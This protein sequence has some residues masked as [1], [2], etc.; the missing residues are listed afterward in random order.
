MRHFLLFSVLIASSVNAVEPQAFFKEHCVK[1]HGED[2]QKGD[3]RLD[4]VSR[5]D[6]GLWQTIYEQVASE[7]MPPD[8]EPQPTDAERVELKNHVLALATEGS[9]P[10][11]TGFRRLNK[12]EYSNTV[13]DL[14]GLQNGIYDPGEY[15]YDDEID[16]GFDTAA[17]E[18]V[19]SNE[20][21]L[22][23]LG[24]AEK[25]LRLALFSDRETKPESRLIDVN[26]RRMRGGSNRYVTFS[27]EHMLL[28]VG[29][30]AKVYDGEQSRVMTASGNYKIT[31]TASGIDRDRYPV[32][33]HPAEGPL[34]LGVGVLQETAASV[35]S[36]GTLLHSVDLKDHE[37]QTFTFD[38]WIDK[39]HYPYLSFVN[40]SGKPITQVRSNIRRRK[41]PKSAAKQ[42]FFGPA[43]RVT[44]Y[45]IEGPFNEDW[46]PKT[47]RTTYDSEEIPDF[48]NADER[49]QLI[50]RFANRAFRRT[51]PVEVV[52]PYLQYLNEQY[53]ATKSWHESF[54]RTF[55]AMMASHDFLYLR[56]SDD[57]LDAFALA[58]RLSYFLWSTMPD[59]ELFALAESGA[60][61]KP[62]VLR[63]QVERLLND[64]RS[65]RFSESFVD[66]W[67]SIDTLG[68]MPPDGKKP[69]FRAYYR[70]N[71][72]SAMREETRLFF[73]HILNENRSVREFIDS[74]YSFLNQ[75]LANLYG[76]PFDGGKQ[77]ERV[78]FPETAKRGGLL[79]HAS[80][81][82][83]TSN[84]VETSPVVRGHWVLDELLGTP[85]PPAPKEVPA[86]VPD[87]Q[88][89]TTVRQQLEK[90]RSEAACME[91]HRRMDPPG[92]ALESFDPIGR[93][94]TNYSPDQLITT[95]SEFNGQKF[96]DVEGL[97]TIMMTQLEP[98]ARSLIVKISEYSKGRKLELADLKTVEDILGASA[99]E[100]FKLR[101][102]IVAIATSEL[103]T[104]R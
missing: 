25:S 65:E 41:I 27:N 9:G 31:V 18:L 8:D 21:L 72:E 13:N 95:D 103:M 44:E 32:K 90:H 45:K 34:K 58:N 48:E 62:A 98:F 74:D 46:P 42:P 14:L 52:S 83:L 66:Q 100:D 1:C 6:L 101:D 71:L 47:F 64:P 96:E 79:G 56:E 59:A 63:E 91:C 86:L 88:G 54:I 39:D 2:K 81:L 4:D 85:P 87:L 17:E 23:Y 43:I 16:H 70:E 99:A 10:S 82:T 93:F 15:I 75:G 37:E 55:A 26:T 80:I 51:V 69:E 40:G 68:S 60:I 67:L 84:G 102:M 19:I 78:V 76:I 36:Q 29:G 11:A 38:V 73:S 30:K 97:K 7:E 20:L 3:V 50:Q 12:R 94:R 22:E 61:T 92:L 49:Q 28:R 104:R 24:S 5:L 35:T 53:F 77:F 57:E 33:F 89:L